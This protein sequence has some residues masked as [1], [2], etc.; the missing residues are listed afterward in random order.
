MIIEFIGSGG[1]CGGLRAAENTALIGWRKS[2][3]IQE[4]A[5]GVVVVLVLPADE[6]M[7][8]VAARRPH[9]RIR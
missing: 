4:L 3:W 9:S 1:G 2:N 6:Q 7:Q 8:T 5:S